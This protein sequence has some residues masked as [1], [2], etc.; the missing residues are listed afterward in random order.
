MHTNESLTLDRVLKEVVVAAKGFVDTC[1]RDGYRESHQRDVMARLTAA[2]EN[3]KGTTV[4]PEL[5]RYVDDFSPEETLIALRAGGCRWSEEILEESFAMRS[6][7]TYHSLLSSFTELSFEL[8][9]DE[10]TIPEQAL[11]GLRRISSKF[12]NRTLAILDSLD[13]ELRRDQHLVLRRSTGAFVDP[14]NRLV[15]VNK[16]ARTQSEVISQA[17]RNIDAGIES[18]PVALKQLRDFDVYTSE[19]LRQESA[20]RFEVALLASVERDRAVLKRTTK[21]Y[22]LLAD[23]AELVIDAYDLVG[24]GYSGLEAEIQTDA[25]MADA[26]RARRAYF[27]QPTPE[28]FEF[29]VDSLSPELLAPRAAQLELGT[30]RSSFGLNMLKETEAAHARLVSI[31]LLGEAAL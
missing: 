30:E 12:H 4:S 3:S 2:A 15:L 31:A 11:D 13:E 10:V 17:I 9:T 27:L 23:H 21:K 29:A 6:W 7:R 24:S 5:D 19:E 22:L 18:L 20:E 25:L 16:G 1:V 8:K 28:R 14:F 26:L